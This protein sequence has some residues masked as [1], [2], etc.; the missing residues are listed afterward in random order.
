MT[1]ARYFLRG[2]VDI[3]RSDALRRAL[4]PFVEKGVDLLIDC[5]QLSFLDS[6]GV[7]V[8]CDT[9]EA[10]EATGHYM[11]LTNVHGAPLRVLEVM[12]LSDLLSIERNALAS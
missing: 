4:A 8:L 6:S 12:Q 9:S 3:A 10:L 1:D 2:D 5:S 11:M 7:A